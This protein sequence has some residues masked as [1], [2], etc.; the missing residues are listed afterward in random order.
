ML[1]VR[2]LAITLVLFAI[3]LPAGAL[4]YRYQ[5]TQTGDTLLNRAIALQ[6]SGKWP[7]A[8][9]YFQRYL[10]LQPNDLEARLKLVE[11]FARQ[12]ETPSSN[13]RLV[14]LL[15]QT[16]GLAPKEEGLQLQ[17]AE[18]LLKTGEF[19]AAQMEAEKL[20]AAHSP[21]TLAAQRVIAM[22]LYARARPGGVVTIEKA[23]NALL[24]AVDA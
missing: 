12:A 9:A 16:L 10:I 15:Y 21:H 23:T 11:V 24:T 20:V 4:W 3:C 17:L 13:R 7:E 14:A 1:N 19:A 2:L 6:E 8:M 5:K 18:T 22:S